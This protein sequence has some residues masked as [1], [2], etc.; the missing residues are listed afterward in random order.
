V[1]RRPYNRDELASF[2]NYG[3]TSV[4][5]AAPGVDILSTVPN[6]GY[7]Q[8][9]GTSMAT[10]HVTGAAALILAVDGSLSYA[11]VAG[12]LMNNGDPCGSVAGK[13]VSGMRLNIGNILPAMIGEDERIRVRTLAAWFRFDDGGRTVQD[14]TLN[15]DWRT[16]WLYAGTLVGDAAVSNTYA[17]PELRR[18]R[19]GRPARL[20]EEAV[21][22]DPYSALEEDGAAAD[23]DGDGLSN[24]T[25]YRA[26]RARMARGLRGLDPFS[27]DTDHDGESDAN[28]DSDQ[29]GLS[30]IVEQNQY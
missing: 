9:S 4:D 3:A 25:E 22:L 15:A 26:A 13:S 18:H 17:P 11:A 29:D 5:L 7:A 10:P 23:I 20:V 16:G 27:A 12:A 24:F 6:N 30:N 19:P 21:G 8:M 2:S 1:S 28:E 14:F